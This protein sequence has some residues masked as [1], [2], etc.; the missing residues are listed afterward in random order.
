MFVLQILFFKCSSS[1]IHNWVRFMQ[2]KCFYLKHDGVPNKD[3]LIITTDH[4]VSH[5]IQSPKN[6]IQLFF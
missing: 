6:K 5:V 2:F 3:N 1:H 4:R